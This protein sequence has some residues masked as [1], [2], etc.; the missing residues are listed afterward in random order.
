MRK[1][2]FI[3]IGV[4]GQA[5]AQHLVDAGVDLVVWNRSPARCEPLRQRGATAAKSVREVFDL[6]ELV[7]LMLAS[8]EAMDEVLERGQPGFAEMVRGRTVVHMG[9]TSPGYSAALASDVR[10]AGGLYVECPVSGS[11][12]PAEAGQLV[13]MLA[14]DHDKVPDLRTRLAP[15][16][17]QVFVCGEVPS[18]LLMKLAVNLF[19]ITM[20]TGLCEAFHFADVHRL[21][22]RLFQAVLDAGP[23]SSVVSKNK[24]PK[25]VEGDYAVQAS[26]V[27]V[28]KNSR[29]VAEAARDVRVASPLLDECHAL[30]SEA[31]SLGHGALDMV[32]VVNAHQARTRSH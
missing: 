31:V 25:L 11:R 2:G 22:M 29:L 27:D 30:F 1:V 10:R 14:G 13:G 20:V 17:H 28:L 15:M 4:M 23:M 21:D 5:M 24:L 7:I 9:T 19:L 3:G 16:C 26:I 12:K 32:A 18:A 8:G 6:A